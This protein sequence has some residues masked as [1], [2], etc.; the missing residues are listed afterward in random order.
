MH[1][2]EGWV[3]VDWDT[4][5][6]APA[7]RDLWWFGVDDWAAYEASTGVTVNRALAELYRARWDLKDLCEYVMRFHRP[8]TGDEDDEKSWKGVCTILDRLA[9]G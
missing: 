3:L 7:E 8:H 1:T 9:R 6:L 4:L 2:D 5:L